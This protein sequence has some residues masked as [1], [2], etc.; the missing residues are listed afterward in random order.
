MTKQKQFTITILNFFDAKVYQLEV[1][2]DYTSSE[3]EYFMEDQG[4]NLNNIEWMVHPTKKIT[5]L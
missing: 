2:K 3:C 4:F 1:P 5:K